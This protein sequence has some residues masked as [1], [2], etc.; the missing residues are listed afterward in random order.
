MCRVW[1]SGVVVSASTELLDSAS[2]GTGLRGI[3]CSV[4]EREPMERRCIRD[5]TALGSLSVE[6]GCRVEVVL[7]GNESGEVDLFLLLEDEEP[8]ETA[9]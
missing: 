5:A 6:S 7:C 3:V 1:V 9:R 4:D 8:G 2:S